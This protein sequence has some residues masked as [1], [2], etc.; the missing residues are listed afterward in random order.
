LVLV[1]RHGQ[2]VPKDELIKLIWADA[3][4]EEANL[5]QN[6]FLLRKVL[7]RDR[8]GRQY[9]ETVP[10]RGYRFVGKVQEEQDPSLDAG[11]KQR[12][13]RI[14]SRDRLSADL[15]SRFITSIA[16]LPLENVGADPD[17]EYF[18]EGVTESII[19]ALSQIPQLRVIARTRVFR[20]KGRKTSLQQLARELNV[21]TVVTGRLI[22]HGDRLTV[23]I[24]F[25]NVA[26]ESQFWGKRYDLKI[27]DISETPVEI[28]QDVLTQLRSKLE[29]PGDEHL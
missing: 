26:D 5:S 28:S 20:Y 2:I 19:N 9:I 13:D 27:T 17:M 1:Q 21:E 24:E 4:V 25:T 10:R 23:Q 15:K 11:V 12:P 16:I 3:F 18:S 6:I 14:S 29:L 22:I 7:G 8:E